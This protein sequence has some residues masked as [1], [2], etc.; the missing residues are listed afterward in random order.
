M[1]EEEFRLLRELVHAHCGIFF[2]DEHALP[3]RA[4]A[5]AAPRGARAPRRSRA[6][7]RFL[8]FDPGRARRARAR[9][10]TSS[11]R[12]RPTSTASRCS[13]TPSR[14][15]SS[16]SSRATARGRAAPADPVRGLLHRRGGLHPRDPREG[17]AACSRAGTVEVVGCDISRRCVALARAG[18]YGEHA[19]RNAGGGADAP[20]VPPARREVGRST[21]PSA[22]WSGSAARTC[23]TRARSRRCR[24]LDVARSAGT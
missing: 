10:S 5:R 14:G 1:S 6:Y 9:R 3:A 4:A 19:F 21:T 22:G 7:H 8:R 12:T 15:R 18:V 20:L 24:A 13:S 11:P 16:P 2:R 17:L 23:S